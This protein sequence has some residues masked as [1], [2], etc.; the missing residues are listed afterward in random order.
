LTE[1]C[2][3]PA[4]KPARH[5][6]KE[7]QGILGDL[8]DAEAM[9]DRETGV[10]SLESLLR[11]RQQL[12]FARFQELWGEEATVAAFAGLEDAVR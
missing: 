1:T 5:A 10:A 11:T 12:L 9:I 8:R 4:G 2:F 7:L 3:E 6:A